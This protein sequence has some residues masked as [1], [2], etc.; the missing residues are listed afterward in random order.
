MKFQILDPSTYLGQKK[1]PKE[2]IN[3]YAVP[4]NIYSQM[5]TPLPIYIIEKYCY[6]KAT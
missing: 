5:Q 4:R 3:F 1:T 6:L 2:D